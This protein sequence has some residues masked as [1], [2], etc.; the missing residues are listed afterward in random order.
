MMSQIGARYW[1]M[2]VHKNAGKIQA[3]GEAIVTKVSE[4]VSEAKGIFRQMMD[5]VE[6]NHGH[7]IDSSDEEN[8]PARGESG[9]IK[10]DIT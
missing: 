8:N 6:M 7:S 3:T 10:W 2:N 1:I 9:G 4:K 5:Y